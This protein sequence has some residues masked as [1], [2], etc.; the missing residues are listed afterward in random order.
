MI[1]DNIVNRVKN[2]PLKDLEIVD[3]C[4]GIPFTYVIIE[5]NGLKFLGT[6]LTPLIELGC[7]ERRNPPVDV[8]SLD[9]SKVVEWATDVH[10]IRRVI[11]MATINAVSQYFLKSEI[12]EFDTGLKLTEILNKVRAEKV[13]VIGY[14]R[15]LVEDLRREGFDFVIFERDFTSR[16]DGFSDCLEPR[17]LPEMDALLITGSSLINDSLDFVLRFARRSKV[18][19]LIG[20]TAQVHPRLMRGFNVH[21]LYSCMVLDVEKAVELLKVTAWRDALFGE[22]SRVYMAKVPQP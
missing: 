5:E 20:P 18:N 10:M 4:I 13:A 14:M 8:Y 15:Y 21:Y 11:G 9:V 12:D 22:F 16:R 2:F 17:M 19:V 7:I 1:I 6:A 3:V